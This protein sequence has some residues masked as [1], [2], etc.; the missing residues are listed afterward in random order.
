MKIIKSININEQ[1]WKKLEV[2]AKQN[3]RSMSN[4]IEILIDDYLK[5]KE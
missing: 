1:L 4:M 5:D 3:K 2:I